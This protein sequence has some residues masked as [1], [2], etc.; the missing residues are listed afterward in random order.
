M[1]D[2]AE[3]DWLKI[4]QDRKDRGES[5]WWTHPLG[6]VHENLDGKRMCPVIPETSWCGLKLFIPMWWA[7]DSIDLQCQ[8]E[9]VWA[10]MEGLLE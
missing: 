1:V 2:K 8:H 5:M 6:N 9:Q 7:E 10:L 4:E 3:V